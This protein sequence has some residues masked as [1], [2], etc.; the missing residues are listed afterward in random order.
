MFQVGKGLL[1]TQNFL[2]AEKWLQ[3]AWDIINSQQLPNLSRSAVELRMAILQ[4][5]VAALLGTQCTDSISRAQNLINYVESEVG[6]QPMVLLLKLELLSKSP[7]ETFDGEAYGNILRRMIRTF[8]PTDANFKLLGHHIHMLHRKAP[9]LACTIL[10]EFLFSLGQSGQTEWIDRMV[11][12]RIHMATSHRDFEGTIEDADKA[13]SK[14]E[15][16]VSPAA[17]FAAQTVSQKPSPCH[18]P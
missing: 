18:Y 7:G 6:D 3:R 11:T 12:T 17:S 14:L 16:P 1:S 4:G 5:L 13:L 15:Q 9:A 8:Q 10:D 2:M